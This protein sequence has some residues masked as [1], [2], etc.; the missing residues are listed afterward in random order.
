MWYATGGYI[1]LR[2][3][4]SIP[5]DD[6]DGIARREGVSILMNRRAAAAWRAPGEEWQ[7]VSS[8]LVITRLK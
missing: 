3:C 2:S 1:L 5:N 6:G 7:A 8:R 4:R